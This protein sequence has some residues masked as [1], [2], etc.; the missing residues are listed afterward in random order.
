M[1]A[2]GYYLIF[3]FV[4]VLIVNNNCRLTRKSLFNFNTFNIMIH[5]NYALQLYTR[6]TKIIIN[7]ILK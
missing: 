7:I 5:D 6:N 4:V 1:S 3:F 2:R